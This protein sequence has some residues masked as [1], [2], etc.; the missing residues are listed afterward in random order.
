[1]EDGGLL[2]NL[3]SIEKENDLGIHVTRDLKSE[4]PCK[5]SARKAQAVLSN[6]WSKGTLQN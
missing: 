5:Q 4:K 6:Q 2:R 1:M 3:D